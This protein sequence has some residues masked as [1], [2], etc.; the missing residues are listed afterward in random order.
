MAIQST[1]YYVDLDDT[2]NYFS[3]KKNAVQRFANEPKFFRRLK[4]N[5]A[6]IKAV[7]ALAKIAKVYIITSSPNERCDNDKRVWSQR[8][9]KGIEVI[10]VRLGDSKTQYMRTTNGVLFDD[11]GKNC[12]EW[13]TIPGNVAC[14][15]TKEHTIGYWLKTL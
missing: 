2:V 6:N 14:K 8:Y 1:T 7:K 15:V 5:M 13:E 11:Y 9:L 4:P 12:K 3:K 10:I